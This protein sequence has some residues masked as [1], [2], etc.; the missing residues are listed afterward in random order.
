MIQSIFHKVLVGVTFLSSVMVA[1]AQTTVKATVDKN[2]I[3]IG[4]HIRLTL[5]ADIPENELIRFFAIDTLPHFEIID[6]QKTDTS[7]TSKGT[8]LKQNIIITS[9]DSGHWVIPALTLGGKIITDSIPVDVSFSDF[10]P[11]KD[12][13]DIKDIIEVKPKKEQKD[14]WLWY[15]TG[16]GSLLLILLLVYLLR[17]KRKP[18][19]AAPVPEINPYEEAMKQLEKIQT[20]KLEQKQY[21]SKLVDIFRLY[22][23]RKKGIHSL[24]KTTDDLVVQLK[25]ISISKELFEKLSQ[26]LRLTDFVKFA[27]YIPGAEDDRNIYDTIKKTITEIEQAS[28]A[29]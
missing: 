28:N 8:F 14:W 25:S 21:Y 18:V 4:E 20:E 6:R 12:Y 27:K 15:A 17:R 7:N 11:A 10:D 16:G 2:K 23:F 26:G 5:Q 24:Q 19:I 29:V 22:V 1:E 3:L 9:F 13:H